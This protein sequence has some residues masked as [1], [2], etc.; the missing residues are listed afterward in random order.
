[1]KVVIHED[2]LRG[3]RVAR[4][5]RRSGEGREFVRLV[6]ERIAEFAGAHA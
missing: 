3:E 4:Q 6:D 1:M 5:S 2:A